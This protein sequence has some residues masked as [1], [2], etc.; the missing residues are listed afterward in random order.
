MARTS[1]ELR[2]TELSWPNQTYQGLPKSVVA[3][4]TTCEEISSGFGMAWRMWAVDSL[5]W[6][7]SREALT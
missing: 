2:K 6:T 7:V 3:S 1:G 4:G 5:I